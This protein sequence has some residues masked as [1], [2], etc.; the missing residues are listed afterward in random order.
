MSDTTLPHREGL[1]GK[2]PVT[3][4]AAPGI[5]AVAGA[6]ATGIFDDSNITWN[7]LEGIDHLT[8]HILKVDPEAKSVDLLLKFSANERII[9]HRHHADYSTFII[10]GELRL[11]DA[12]GALTEIRPTGS[13]V[14]KPGGGA[15]HTE[16][17]GDIDCIAWFSNRGT[18]G[19][20]YEILGPNEETL[21]TLGL[22]DFMALWDAQ[23]PPVASHLPG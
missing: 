8:Y 19:I 2:T 9:L 5:D 13:F 15:P 14:E 6:S 18:D 23:D 21:A 4:A 22:P 1:T 12:D 17:G 16:G 11:Y 7:A 3:D 20:I 10:Q